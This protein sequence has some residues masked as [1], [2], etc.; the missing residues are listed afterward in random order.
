[1]VEVDGEP[2]RLVAATYHLPTKV[3]RVQLDCSI[4]RGYNSNGSPSSW[5]LAKDARIRLW[6]LDSPLIRPK[7][8]GYPVK[9]RLSLGYYHILI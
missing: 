3:G 5:G 4:T 9:Q 8:F 1:M 2:V 7:S 6:P